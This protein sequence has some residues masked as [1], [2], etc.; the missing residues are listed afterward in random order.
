M[1]QCWICNAQADSGEHK[2]KKSDLKRTMSGTV[3]PTSPIY[4]R[5]SGEKKRPIGSLKAEALK[6]D[7]NLCGACNSS[8]SQPHDYAWD[9]LA[10]YLHEV[11]F[12]TGT[13]IELSKV[14]KSETNFNLI[15][16][17]LFFAKIFGCAIAETGFDLNL[18]ILA[19]SIMENTSCPYLYLKIRNSDN[20]KTDSYCALSDIEVSRGKSGDLQYVHI[21]YIVGRYSIDIVYSENAADLDLTNYFQPSNTLTKIRLGSIEYKQGYQAD[22]TS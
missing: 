5:V 21:Y 22:S 10:S 2:I 19:K 20:G 16:V 9:V 4:H 18:K 11:S 6:F 12:E 13:E 17:H 14:F 3:N 15:N 1:P 7:K 8:L